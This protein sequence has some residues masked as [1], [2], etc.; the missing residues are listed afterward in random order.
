[1][2]QSWDYRHALTV[3]NGVFLRFQPQTQT[4]VYSKTQATSSDQRGGLQRSEQQRP[5]ILFGR[6]FSANVPASVQKGLQVITHKR[7]PAFTVENLNVFYCRFDKPI[8]TPLQHQTATYTSCH[9]ATLPTDLPPALRICK[10]NVCQLSEKEDQEGTRIRWS[11]TILPEQIC[12]DQHS[13]AQPP[14]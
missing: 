9:P 4:L 5:A 2:S 14:H 1:M 13:P 10:E 3:L 7:Q 6:R 12:A 11:V 8:F